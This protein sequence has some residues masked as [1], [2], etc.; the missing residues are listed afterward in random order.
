MS[1][2]PST[3]SLILTRASTNSKIWIQMMSC[4]TVRFCNNTARRFVSKEGNSHASI[5][6]PFM[7]SKLITWKQGHRSAAARG[8]Q[9]KSQTT[10]E[11]RSLTR[12]RPSTCDAASPP[13]SSE[14]SIQSIQHGY[15]HKQPEQVLTR[16]FTI[17][18]T[19]HWSG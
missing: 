10:T 5:T 3:A 4:A 11:S 1:S 14:H 15:T 18:C 6:L 7:H 19:S 16:T 12:T 2:A 9:R 13:R 8:D 17:F